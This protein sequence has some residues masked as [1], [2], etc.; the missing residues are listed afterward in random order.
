M[1]RLCEALPSLADLYRLA[2]RPEYADARWHVPA[3]Q[4]TRFP[5]AGPGRGGA[6]AV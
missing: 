6:P 5:F 3:P 2:V 1:Q 4:S